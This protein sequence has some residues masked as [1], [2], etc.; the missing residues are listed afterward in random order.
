MPTANADK[1]CRQLRSAREAAGLS[2]EFIADKLKVSSVT[3][4]RLED[5]RAR[6][7]TAKVAAYAKVLGLRLEL[8]GD[9]R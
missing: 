9:A 4:Q 6:P 5:G 2:I 3:V 8:V 7:T 1:L